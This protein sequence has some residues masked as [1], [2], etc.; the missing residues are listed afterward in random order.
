M[1]ATISMGMTWKDPRLAWQAENFRNIHDI[2][3]N[4]SSLWTPELEFVNR[5]HDYS[6]QDEKIH[7]A[8]VTSD[9]SVIWNR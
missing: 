8:K 1:D 9:G 6:Y 4:P 7:K 3:L 5:I 2:Q